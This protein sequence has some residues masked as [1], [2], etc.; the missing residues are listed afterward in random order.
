MDGVHRFA[1]EALLEEMP[2]AHVLAVVVIDVR[3]G[4][5]LE[6]LAHFFLALAEEQV[7]VV[8]HEAVGVI[9][10]VLSG[11]KALVVVTDAEALHA[12]HKVLIIFRIFED[13]LVVDSAHHDVVDAGGGSMSCCSWHGGCAN[14]GAK[15]RL[16]SRICK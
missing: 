10:A 8:G 13:Y 5:A 7:E 4:D 6:R 12:L 11:W 2:A 9:G 14:C 3:V 16:F 1:A 15:L